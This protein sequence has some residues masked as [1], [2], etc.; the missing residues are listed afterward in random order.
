MIRTTLTSAAC[1]AVFVLSACSSDSPTAVAA[2]PNVATA[3]QLEVAFADFKV[4][5]FAGQGTGLGVNGPT[6]FE[7]IGADTAAQGAGF[8]DVKNIVA[9]VHE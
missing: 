8:A 4:S 6:R 9:G 2:D 5:D 7:E 1:A 3:A